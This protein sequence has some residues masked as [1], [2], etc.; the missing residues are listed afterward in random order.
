MAEIKKELPLTD[1]CKI[2]LRFL[3]D[4][5]KSWVGSDLAEETGVKGIHP[6]CNSLVKRGLV[7][8]GSEEREFTNKKGETGVKEYVT[9]SLT[10][11][12]RDYIA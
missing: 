10:D 5:D 4:N 11:A 2:V 1:N 8:K 6:V 12:G 3:Q 9:Y 7:Q